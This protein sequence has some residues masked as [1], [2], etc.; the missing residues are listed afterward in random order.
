[1]MPGSR[2]VALVQSHGPSTSTGTRC[3][4]AC[5]DHGSAKV[6]R[7]TWCNT[8][9]CGS[10]NPGERLRK[11]FASFVHSPTASEWMR[12]ATP[13]INATGRV[14]GRVPVAGRAVD[15]TPAPRTVRPAPAR[16]DTN[17]LA[18]PRRTRA[19][20]CRQFAFD[21][22]E[23]PVATTCRERR[24]MGNRPRAIDPCAPS[25][26][27]ERDGAALANVPADLGRLRRADDDQPSSRCS[28]CG[29]HLARPP[30]QSP[31]AAS[32]TTRRWLQPLTLTLAKARLRPSVA[33]RASH[34]TT[35]RTDRPRGA[36]GDSEPVPG[37]ACPLR[38]SHRAPRPRHRRC[39]GPAR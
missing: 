8:R 27:G 35:T 24:I 28:A 17:R 36:V 5:A 14:A 10:T 31:V 39:W 2:E 34:S 11:Y 18:W 19:A 6:S 3:S 26:A 9:F 13:S 15:P 37:A 29:K 21:A 38:A 33:R 22:D 30:R 32:F 23:R 16:T 20:R 12:C 4:T 25:I 7:C 1:M